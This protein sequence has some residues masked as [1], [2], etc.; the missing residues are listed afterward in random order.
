VEYPLYQFDCGCTVPSDKVLRSC[1]FPDLK[2]RIN[3]TLCPEHPLTSKLTGKM[4]RCERCGAI[5]SGPAMCNNRKFC[6]VCKGA[7]AAEASRKFK[8]ANPG[9]GVGRI[10][11]VI[12]PVEKIPVEFTAYSKAEPD[13]MPFRTGWSVDDIIDLQRWGYSTRYGS[14]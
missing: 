3:K 8:A 12:S 5:M 1:Y 14:K 4:F 11:V 10:R 7:V 13:M 9:Y 2:R 6:D